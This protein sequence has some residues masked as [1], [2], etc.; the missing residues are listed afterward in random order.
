MTVTIRVGV[1]LGL[2]ALAAPAVAGDASAAA[3]TP[4]AVYGGTLGSAALAAGARRA[5]TSR[6]TGAARCAH[7]ASA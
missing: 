7:R 5:S 2:A 1:L 4:S 3:A 6:P